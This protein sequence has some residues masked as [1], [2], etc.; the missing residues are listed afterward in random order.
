MSEEIKRLL[1]DLARFNHELG[2]KS[3]ESR[4]TRR[5]LRQ[6]KFFGGLKGPR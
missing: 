2:S 3:K 1:D 6:L 4:A 5:R